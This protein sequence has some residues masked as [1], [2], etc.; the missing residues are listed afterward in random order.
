[1]NDQRQASQ[2][3][4]ASWLACPEKRELLRIACANALR[5]N[6]GEHLTAAGREFAQTWA[7]EPPLGR[8]LSDG[9]PRNLTACDQCDAERAA[10]AQAE[11][12]RLVAEH[13]KLP[14]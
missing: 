11:A 2:G 4:P 10:A 5:R 9:A 6:G 8:P 3:V 7:S 1:M 12:E 13:T 14:A